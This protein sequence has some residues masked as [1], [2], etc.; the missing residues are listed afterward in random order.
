SRA[1]AVCGDRPVPTELRPCEESGLG[2]AAGARREG[3]TRR[4]Q[5]DE[6]RDALARARSEALANADRWRLAVERVASVW[7]SPEPSAPR[8]VVD[9]RELPIWP[10]DSDD[11]L[12]WGSVPSA[13][14]PAVCGVADVV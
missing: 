9:G 12:A 7:S 8:N 2:D 6:G 13:A 5:L 3:R 11:V 1:G 14:Q 10:P 4:R